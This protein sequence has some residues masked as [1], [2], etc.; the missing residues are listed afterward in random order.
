ML[1]VYGHAVFQTIQDRSGEF[2][3]VECNPRLGG[4]STLSIACGL[5]SFE[6]FL[7]EAQGGSLPKMEQKK[8]EYRQVR[9]PADIIF[10]LG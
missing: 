4:A 3:L 2:V 6:W 9:Y 1:G 10:P 8:Q 7:L 5:K